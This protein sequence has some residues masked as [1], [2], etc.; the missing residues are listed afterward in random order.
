MLLVDL[1]PQANATNFL[2]LTY[3][4]D[5]SEFTSL[6][7]AMKKRNNQE[8]LILLSDH[9]HMFPSAVDLSAFPTYLY[10]HSKIDY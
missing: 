7:E 9:L 3:D 4:Y 1:D 5:I 6:Y 10:Q 8:A 2:S